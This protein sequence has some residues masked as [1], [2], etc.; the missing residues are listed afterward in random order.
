M[1]YLVNVNLNKNELQNAVLQPLAAAPQSPA[2]YQIYTN[3]V[4]N[5]IYQNIGTTAEPNWKPVG[6]VLSVNGK[7][8]VVVLTQD[9][10]GDGTTYVRTHNDLTD[11]LA[12]QITT[13]E[14]DIAAIEDKIPTE[15]STSNQ[16]ADKQFV[17]DSITQGTA[18]FRGSYATKAALDAVAWQTSDQ[19]AQYYVSNNDYAVVL[20]DETHDG[21]CWRYIYVISS[22]TGAWTAQYRINEA[23][24]TQAQ[25][26][27]LNSGITSAGVTQI[28]TN[29]TQIGN[30]RAMIAGT[31]ASTTSSKAYSTGDFFIL[32]DILYR[33]TADIAQGGTIAVS[34]AGAN[35]EAATIGDILAGVQ[36]A[37]TF[38]TTPTQN[39]TNPVTSGGV[40]TAVNSVVQTA[41]GTIATT[42]T[43]TVVN[44]TGTVL[45]AYASQSGARV[46]VDISDSGSAITFTVAQNPSAAIT[47]TV[48]YAQAVG[49]AAVQ[50]G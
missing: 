12:A 3:T 18:I 13:N 46:M 4:D 44:Y 9:D 16:L 1:N 38:D 21:E 40:Y 7:T 19:T 25:L 45:E 43:S 22:G 32:N 30:T 28:G 23:P 49:Q 48:V 24:M 15:A 26:D 29:T 27:A 2:P 47:C 31:E 39:S 14:T 36:E 11:A 17:T 50:G 5:L 6:A 35:A 33:A 20:A 10:V 8:G 41:T 42:G 34:G 37:L